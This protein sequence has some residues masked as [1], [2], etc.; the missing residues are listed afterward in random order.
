VRAQVAIEQARVLA[1][2][3]G[4]AISDKDV[5][6]YGKATQQTNELAASRNR[7]NATT[8]AAGDRRRAHRLPAEQGRDRRARGAGS[9]RRGALGAAGAD[10]KEV[11]AL[12]KLAKERPLDLQLKVDASRARLE[13]EKLKAEPGPAE[14]EVRRHLQGRRRE[15]VRRPDER[16]E[17]AGGDPQLRELSIA[18]EINATV[19]KRPVQPRCSARTGPWAGRRSSRQPVR[20]QGSQGR[21]AGHLQRRAEPDPAHGRRRPGDQRAAALGEAAQATAVS[22]RQVTGKDC[23]QRLVA[24]ERRRLRALRPQ[25]GRRGACR[26]GTGATGDFARFDRQT[27]LTASRRPWTC[28][29]RLTPQRLPTGGPRAAC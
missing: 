8:P 12:E 27:L 9:T 18:K 23:R 13:L 25:G 19:G 26:D 14:G 20:R 22:L 5:D 3:S 1:K 4:G 28:S 24:S 7:L 2:Q 16:H 10:Q 6:A 29:A 15:P 21:G 11:E 17:A